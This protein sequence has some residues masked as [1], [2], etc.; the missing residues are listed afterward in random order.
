MGTKLV[1]INLLNK[2]ILKTNLNLTS[3]MTKKKENI[4]TCDNCKAEC[5]RY[6]AIEIDTPETLDDFEDIKWYVCHE[7]VHVYVEEDGTWNVEFIT[8]CRHLDEN[9]RCTYYKKRPK[10]C[11]E[12]NQNE[13]TFHNDYNELFSFRKIQDVEEYIEKIFKKGLHKIPTEEES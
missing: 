13:C 12:Y 10:I 4:K 11:R 7:N 9:N 2:L 6:V 5:C 3:S 8:P 1:Y